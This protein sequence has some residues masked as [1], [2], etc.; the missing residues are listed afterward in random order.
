MVN[1]FQKVSFSLRKITEVQDHAERDHKLFTAAACLFVSGLCLARLSHLILFHRLMTAKTCLRRCLLAVTIFTVSGSAV[2]TALFIFTCRPISKS[3]NVSLEGTCID[4]PVVFVAVA[5]QNI[6]SDICLILLPIPMIYELQ[7]SRSQKLKLAV[8]LAVVCLYTRLYH[9]Q[10]SAHHWFP[11][12]TFIASAIR[13]RVTVPLLGS[14]DLTY[15]VAPVAL[16]VYGNQCSRV[17]SVAGANE[18][19]RCRVQHHRHRCL[20]SGHWANCPLVQRRAPAI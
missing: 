1:T 19:K 2:L 7:M 12:S 4:R 16:L 14:N 3:W 17:F 10:N 5:V 9:Q 20:C 13:L 18:P 8:L 15:G 11:G 6:V